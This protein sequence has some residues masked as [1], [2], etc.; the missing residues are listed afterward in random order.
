MGT[1][2]QRAARWRRDATARLA[3]FARREDG[4]LSVEF[5]VI[6][7][8]MLLMLAGTIEL[9]DA[10]AA[11]RRLD[12]A[13]STLGDLPANGREDYLHWDEVVGIMD[14]TE[15][16]MLPYGTGDAKLVLTVITYDEDDERTEVVWSM[17]K[18][19]GVVAENAEGGY[20]RGDEFSAL[21]AVSYL[22]DGEDFANANHHLVVAEVTYDYAPVVV[23]SYVGTLRFQ[24]V[25]VRLPRRKPWLHLCQSNRP[26]ADCTD[27][28]DWLESKGE[29]AG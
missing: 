25:E 13:V 12:I 26:G 3:R 15:L 28:R 10:L 5:A 21:P 22:G 18:E 17:V 8:V 2:P 7:P 20:Q 9:S 6:L 24:E 14:A 11:K 23:P 29:P 19:D 27:G 4:V 16:M 1:L